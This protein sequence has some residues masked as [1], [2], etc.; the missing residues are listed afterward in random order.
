MLA[1]KRGKRNYWRIVAIAAV[2]FI[3]LSVAWDVAYRE[4]LRAGKNVSA[5]TTGE[6]E[7]IVGGTANNEGDVLNVKCS[8]LT[9]TRW[10]CRVNYRDG[11]IVVKI[12]T[13]YA[14]SRSLGMTI[15][16]R[17]HQRQ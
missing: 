8:P 2:T 1:A 7:A 11:R 5:K 16:G 14:S 17:Y 10:K 12:A 9:A 6:V 3:M 15:V 4:L 13:W